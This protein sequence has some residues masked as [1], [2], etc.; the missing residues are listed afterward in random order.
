[1]QAKL[2][3]RYRL[4]E[5]LLRPEPARQRDERILQ[6]AHERLA[7]VHGADA[8]EF[9][10]SVV[11]DLTRHEVLRDAPPRLAA[12]PQH[13][14]RE[15]PHQAHI[16]ATVDQPD[17]APCQFRCKLLGGSAVL[18]AAPRTG[19]AEKADSDHAAL[20]SLAAANAGRGNKIV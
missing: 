18:G 7:L 5:L 2:R 11:P 1:M 13:G 6:V 10:Q 3:P 9:R 8:M 15:H 12:R 14:V 20:L 19:A 17:V 4:A 16:A